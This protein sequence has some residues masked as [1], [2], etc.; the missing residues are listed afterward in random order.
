[1]RRET[2]DHAATAPRWVFDFLADEVR[3]LQARMDALIARKDAL[4]A[5]P[6]RAGSARPNRQA[7]F[8]CIILCIA[9]SADFRE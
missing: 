8:V 5:R 2:R 4:K 1:M 3:D 6:N 7:D 9:L